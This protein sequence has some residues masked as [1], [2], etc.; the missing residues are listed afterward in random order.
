MYLLIL[1]SAVPKKSCLKVKRQSDIDE[2]GR[3]K[4]QTHPTVP[5]TEVGKMDPMA[6]GESISNAGE[7]PGE[8]TTS[9]K[10]SVHWPEGKQIETVREFRRDTH[11]PPPAVRV[12]FRDAIRQEHALEK[13]SAEEM[14]K[15]VRRYN[16][17]K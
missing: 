5:G 8:A 9:S 12:D 15:N 4:A 3:V 16:K 11:Y 1:C 13:R 17:M 14:K 7:E 2:E 6:D 10:K